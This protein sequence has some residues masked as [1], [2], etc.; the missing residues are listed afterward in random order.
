MQ[1]LDVLEYDKYDSSVERA[2][3]EMQ[4]EEGIT[5]YGISL[6]YESN[7]GEVA[8]EGT[9]YGRQRSAWTGADRDPSREGI[10]GGGA[11]PERVRCRRCRG[12]RAGY[13]G[14]FTEA[15]HKRGGLHQRGR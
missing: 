7:K 13:G 4:L 3:S 14:S 11:L 9:D 8:I 12:R 6:F 1:L 10:R 2:E 5:K 15:G